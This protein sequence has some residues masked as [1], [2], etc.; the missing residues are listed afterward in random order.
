MDGVGAGSGDITLFLEGELYK[1]S[2]GIITKWQKRFFTIK[3]GILLSFLFVVFSLFVC[4]LVW[5]VW[6]VW[7]VC[8]VC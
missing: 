1:L 4:L 2:T 6:L 7:L 5:L 3:A 8:L